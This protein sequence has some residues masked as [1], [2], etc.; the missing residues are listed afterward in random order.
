MESDPFFNFVI[1]IVLS[2]FFIHQNIFP[3]LHDL[4]TLHG[5]VFTLKLALCQKLQGFSHVAT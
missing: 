1:K 3:A 4:C 2:A 5:G